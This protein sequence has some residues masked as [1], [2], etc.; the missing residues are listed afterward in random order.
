MPHIQ[1]PSS[2]YLTCWSKILN[3]VSEAYLFTLASN[4]TTEWCFVMMMP[5]KNSLMCNI[6]TSDR[7]ANSI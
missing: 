1:A 2:E 7:V 4:G 3:W 5:W 6:L